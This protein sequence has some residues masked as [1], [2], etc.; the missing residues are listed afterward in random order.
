MVGVRSNGLDARVRKLLPGY[1]ISVGQTGMADM[2]EMPVPMPANS[3]PM[4]GA[5]RKHDY[6]S[7]LMNRL[8]THTVNN[9]ARLLLQ[10]SGRSTAHHASGRSGEPGQPEK[11]AP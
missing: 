9:P 10:K 2:G 4:L 7:M 11:K 6:H 5:Q 3:I 8:E 1:N